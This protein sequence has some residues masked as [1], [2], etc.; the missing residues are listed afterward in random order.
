MSLQAAPVLLRSLLFAYSM[1]LDTTCKI[2]LSSCSRS[3][4]EPAS[5]GICDPI[6]VS[7]AVAN[8]EAFAADEVVQLYS[9]CPCGYAECQAGTCDR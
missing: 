7:V 5:P 6:T 8:P 4:V 1:L 9:C 3:Q 2:N